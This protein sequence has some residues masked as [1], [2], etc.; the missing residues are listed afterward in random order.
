MPMHCYLLTLGRSGHQDRRTVV[1]AYTAQDA[2]TIAEAVPAFDTHDCSSPQ[3][4]D[5]LRDA[6]ADSGG[7]SRMKRRA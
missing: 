1:Q 4:G 2:V 6:W 5:V 3:L 7:V